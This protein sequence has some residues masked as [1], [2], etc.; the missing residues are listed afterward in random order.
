MSVIADKWAEVTPTRATYYE[1]GVRATTRDWS[2]MT[3]AAE[4]AYAQGVQEAV[5]R[6]AFS[7][8][9]G[10]A[11]TAKW[12]EQTLAKKGRWSEGVRLGKSNYQTGFAP[13]RAVIEGVSL[14]PRGPRGDPSNYERS[15][16]IGDALHAARVAGS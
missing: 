2:A 11:G 5:A 13:F 15:R 3:Q 4:S 10:D 16:A 1:S 12:R 8:G 6:G 7:D 14:P 9:V